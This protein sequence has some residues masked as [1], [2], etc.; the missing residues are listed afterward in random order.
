MDTDHDRCGITVICGPRDVRRGT[1]QLRAHNAWYCSVALIVARHRAHKS[2]SDAASF[3]SG[4]NLDKVVPKTTGA[5]RSFT[6]LPAQ[7][8]VSR[9]APKASV[10]FN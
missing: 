10:G 2:E 7:S 3:V 4:P 8:S 5:W 6:G 1:I 9:K